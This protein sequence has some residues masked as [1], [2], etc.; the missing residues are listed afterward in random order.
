M[1]TTSFAWVYFSAVVSLLA[2]LGIAQGMYESDQLAKTRTN[3]TSYIKYKRNMYG[4]VD[5]KAE[6]EL[7]R[8]RIRRGAYFCIGSIL[9]WTLW[10]VLYDLN[11]DSPFT[12]VALLMAHAALIVC[13]GLY[14]RS[15]IRGRKF[16]RSDG[17]EMFD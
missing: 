16:K 6:Y 5:K 11:R 10:I 17:N 13:L 12:F 4:A 3:L 7:L 9:I 1:E 8:R 15:L 14:I 2:V